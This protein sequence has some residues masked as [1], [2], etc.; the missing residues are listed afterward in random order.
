MTGLS[1]LLT[2]EMILAVNGS[3]IHC[4]V[5]NNTVILATIAVLNGA[6]YLLQ[7]DIL[8]EKL[9]WKIENFRWKP[10]QKAKSENT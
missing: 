5:N 8:N 9:G 10:A 2:K 7:L 1:Y 3:V 6:K 4:V